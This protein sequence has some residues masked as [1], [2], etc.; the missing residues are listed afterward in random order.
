MIGLSGKW[1]KWNRLFL[2]ITLIVLYLSGLSNTAQA[3]DE[4]PDF[5]GVWEMEGWSA[6]AWDVEPP[7]SEAGLAAFQ[8]W[9]AAPENDPAHLCIL[10]LVRITTAPMPHEII[11]Q[12][13][14]IL[15]LYEYEHQVRRA[16]MDGRGHPDSPYPTL[17]GYSVG[18]WEG[19]NLIIESIGLGKGYLRPQGTP[20]SAA[21]KVIERRTMLDDGN[22]KTLETIIID[23]EYYSEPWSVTTQW[24]RTDAEI[25]DYDCIPR[26]HIA[27]EY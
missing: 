15:L 12:N 16:Y 19:E 18:S 27:D 23:P 4:K 24:R 1:Y 21:L 11:Q 20:H 5:S 7:Y 14:R 22:T 10:N 13:D 9:Q 2:A 25:M 26:P 8:A 3:A 17:M 6:D